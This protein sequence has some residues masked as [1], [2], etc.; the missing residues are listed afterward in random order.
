MFGSSRSR[1]KTASQEASRILEAAQ[2]AR[3]KADVARD[4][5]H[6]PEARANYETYLASHPADAALW[7]QLG[8]ACKESGDLH[9]ADRAYFRALS[10]DGDGADVRLQIGHLE[11]VRGNLEGA[12][13]WYQRALE[14]DPAFEPAQSELQAIAAE[15]GHL[16]ARVASIE[17]RLQHMDALVGT[18]RALGTEVLRLRQR[19]EELSASLEDI[20]TQAAQSQS[21]RETVLAEIR[22]RIDSL[23]STRSDAHISLSKLYANFVDLQRLDKGQVF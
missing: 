23:E 6:W 17:R 2:D 16:D 11:K 14:A 8:H 7:V 10:L 5:G 3:L 21:S 13:A 4:Q 22:S 20:A 1:T 9:A 15:D 12:R 19:N 18:V